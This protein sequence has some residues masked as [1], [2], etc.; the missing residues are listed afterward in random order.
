[1]KKYL[2][3]VIALVLVVGGYLYSSHLANSKKKRAPQ[4]EKIQQSVF[5]EIVENATIP[6][7]IIEN[8]RLTASN[9]IAIYAEVQGVMEATKKEFKAGTVY[10]K[11]DVMVKIYADDKRASL[12]AQRSILENLIASIL[13]D[14]RVGQPKAYQKWNNYLKSFEVNT[15][16][17]TL[18]E[19]SS[20]REK[21]FITS[22]NVYTTYYQTRNLEIVFQKYQIVAPF[23]GILT[24][25]SI[26]LGSLVMPGQKLGEYIE[27]S[28]YEV[29]VWVSKEAALSL[30]IGNQVEIKNGRLKH[31]ISG[32]IARINGKV[33]SNSQTV[34]VFIKVQDSGLKEGL[35]LQAVMQGNPIE[36]AYEVANSLLVN[37]NQLYVVVNNQINLV[38]VLIMHKKTSSVVVQGLEDGM[39]LV[40]KPLPGAYAGMDVSIIKEDQ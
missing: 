25:A 19:T 6:I 27:P 38:S 8:G 5:V 1:M 40:S 11:N 20:D 4:V 7:Q 32:V 34:R 33:E 26:T 18:P 10:Q 29:E 39:K 13:P 23:D 2:S 37:G 21:Y 31:K 36:N 30:A 3:I 12:L 24:E 28:N 17:E 22:K 9:K 15:P 35:Y 16:I 14:L